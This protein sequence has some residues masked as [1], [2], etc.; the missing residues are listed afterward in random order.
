MTP[1]PFDPTHDHALL[2]AAGY[3]HEFIPADW[4]D[5]G[6][7][8]NGPKLDGH[9]DLHVYTLAIRPGVDHAIVIDNGWVVEVCESPSAPPGWFDD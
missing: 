8:E 2:A 3:V 5:S 1:I 7:S 9:P 4:W 6:D